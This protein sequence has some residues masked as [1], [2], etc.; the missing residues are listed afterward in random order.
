MNQMQLISYLWLSMLT[1]RP[2]LE[3][4]LPFH[5]S[6]SQAGSFALGQSNYSEYTV[7]TIAH[8]RTH[9]AGLL[10]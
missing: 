4:A 1:N 5:L 7:H 9:P 3:T 6:V 10:R 8:Y 2:N